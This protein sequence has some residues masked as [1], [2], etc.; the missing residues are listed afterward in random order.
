VGF[1]GAHGDKKIVLQLLLV[2]DEMW[3]SL[4]ELVAIFQKQMFT[5]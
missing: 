4:F 2:F 5:D 3:P 1:A